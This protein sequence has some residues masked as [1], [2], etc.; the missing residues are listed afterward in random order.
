MTGSPLSTEARGWLY[1]LSIYAL[2]LALHVIL[3]PSA[4]TPGY[5]CDAAPHGTIPRRVLH[6][7]HNGLRVLLTVV[8]TGAALSAAGVIP[9]A[10]DLAVCFWPALRAGCA[11]GLALSLW[12][13]FRGKAR[14][15]ALRVDRGASCPTTNGARSEAA[16]DPAE[17]EGR[18][19][20]EHFYCGLEWNPR[21]ATG[22]CSTERPS[23]LVS[24]LNPNGTADV[25]IK[26]MTY[27][28]GA[29]GLAC[30]VLSALALHVESR[31]AEGGY[32]SSVS[33]AMVAYVNERRREAES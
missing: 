18:S 7:R 29:V 19:T 5:A 25:D 16:C 14:L 23:M 6:Y 30:N 15:A 27:L 26:M 2:S 24:A 33:N 1:V 22:G 17:F 4:A 28:V 10:G 11:C 8:L 20:L 3:P 21:V 9:H 31:R 13:H 32:H 12:L